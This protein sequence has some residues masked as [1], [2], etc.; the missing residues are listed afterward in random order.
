MTARDAIEWHTQIATEFDDRYSKSKSFKERAGIWGKLIDQYSNPRFS[1]LDVGC[2]SGV[3]SF[4]LAEKNDRVV[5]FDASESMLAIC[6][7]K[8]KA[9]SVD[10]VEFKQ[11]DVQQLSEQ[12]TTQNDLV[13]C[14][15]VLEYV[16]DLDHVLGQLKSV[17]RKDGVLILS[18]PNRQSLYRKMERVAYRLLKRPKYYQFVKNVWTLRKMK[19]RLEQLGFVI[20]ESAYYGPAPGISAIFRPLGLRRFSDNLFVTV[21]TLKR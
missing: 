9:R 3:F 10:N 20:N 16:E 1:A 7:E 4:Y 14:S 6:E 17:L 15:S 13:I 21:A 12:C 11:A 5:G 19:E 8:K 18:M 2:G